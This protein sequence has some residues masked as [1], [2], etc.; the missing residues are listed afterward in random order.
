MKSINPVNGEVI[1]EYDEMSIIDANLIVTQMEI[2]SHDWRKKTIDDRIM[3]VKNIAINLGEN[4]S[5]LANMATLEMGKKYTESVAEIEKCIKLCEYYISNAKGFLKDEYPI[6][7]NINSFITYQPL[8]IILGIMPWNFPYW[9]VFRF[10]I[11]TLLAGNCCVL[12]H[13]SNVTGCALAIENILKES[14]DIENIFKVLI[15]KSDSMDELIS[16]DQIRAVSLTGG[17]EAGKAVA[18]SCAK[19]LKKLVLELGGN[20]PYII[21]KDADIEHAAEVCVKSRLIN[22]GQSCIA[23]KRFIVESE[24]YDEFLDVFTR[25]MQEI[26]IGDPLD[27]DVDIG[28]LS[29]IEHRDFL[30]NQVQEC[31]KTGAK[32]ILGGTI[33]EIPG[34]FY[35]PTILTEVTEGMP[36]YD[37]EL[38]GPVASIIRTTGDL[39]AVSVANSSKY[40]LGAAIF[41]KDIE[42][43]KE[44]AK[45]DLQAGSCFINDFVKSDPALPFGGIKYS[46]YG[47]ELSCFGIR[48]FTNI[49]TIVIN[50]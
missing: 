27:T 4:K 32:C 18:L 49:K 39:G 19:H 33:P 23:A 8:G 2:S 3:V 15:L 29:S 1:H 40:G 28:P 20:D 44:L 6:E 41:S 26:N 21:L 38:F 31:I 14:S 22:A 10:I 30:H 45:Y 17:T 25:K 16:N 24:V 36:A 12:K 7:G 5:S 42:A 35:N 43:A 47:R 48:E 34:A 37:D 13:A 9:Q 50:Q 11:P 46:G